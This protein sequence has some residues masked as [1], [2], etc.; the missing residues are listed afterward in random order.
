MSCS[1]SRATKSPSRVG[2]IAT[3]CSTR[4]LVG[5][6]LSSISGRNEA[7]RADVDVGATSHVNRGSRSDWTTTAYRCPCCSWPTVFRGERSRYTSPRTQRLHV[8]LY[9]P[10]LGDVVRIG[11]Q[12]DGLGA[13][14][15]LSPHP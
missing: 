3:V 12:R 10:H 9:P 2:S 13:Q 14:P 11:G 8:G 15:F 6:P 7:G 1:G 4:T 5:R